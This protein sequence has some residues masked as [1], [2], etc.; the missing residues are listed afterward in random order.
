[1]AV[2]VVR[3]HRGIVVPEA[4]S[5][6]V[7][8]QKPPFVGC[9]VAVFAVCFRRLLKPASC[10][11]VIPCRS[12]ESFPFSRDALIGCHLPEFNVRNLPTGIFRG[13]DLQ[14]KF[15]RPRLQR[16]LFCCHT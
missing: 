5:S 1:M 2:S 10:N 6:D 14:L 16:V 11:S 13:I 4:Q 3:C 9:D 7:F 15:T 12:Q 8:Y